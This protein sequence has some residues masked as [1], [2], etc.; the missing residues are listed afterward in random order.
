MEMAR[1]QRHPQLKTHQISDTILHSHSHD[2]GGQAL[3][4]ALLP[5]QNI[6]HSP[7]KKKRTPSDLRRLVHNVIILH[8]TM[9]H[10]N[11]RA[12]ATGVRD[13]TIRNTG[14][15]YTDIMHVAKH[16]QCVP[17]TLAKWTRSLTTSTEIRP[18]IPFDVVSVDGLGPYEPPTIKGCKRAI[19][20]IDC[21]TG[22]MMGKLVRHYNASTLQEFL[23]EIFQ[24]AKQHQFRVRL[25]RYDAGV[26]E[27]SHSV[28]TFLAG[29]GVMGRPATPE[30]QHQNPVERHIRTLKET[31]AANM[32]AQA[33]LEA[34]FWGHGMTM[35]IQQHNM[36]PNSLCETSPNVEIRDIDTDIRLQGTHYFGETVVVEKMGRKA[37][38]GEAR[39]ELARVVGISSL[40]NGGWI[41]VKMG[42]RR[43]MV[44]YNPQ[45]ISNFADD[46]IQQ[47]GGDKWLP[48][49]GL[50]GT[51]TFTSRHS[52]S[53]QQEEAGLNGGDNSTEKGDEAV[54]KQI[55]SSIPPPQEERQGDYNTEEIADET[56]ERTLQHDTTT[57][58]ITPWAYQDRDD[59]D[60]DTAQHH[61]GEVVLAGE[62][63]SENL[64]NPTQDQDSRQPISTR[65]S[66]RQRTQT[67]LYSPEDPHADER[68]N[69]FRAMSLRL[70]TILQS[71]Q[72]K[73]T[74]FTRKQ[75]ERM[76]DAEEWE[77][78]RT[79]EKNMLLSRQT[80]IAEEPAREDT[81]INTKWTHVRKRDGTYKARLCCRGDQDSYDGETFAPTANKSIVWL[82]IAIA[83]ILSLHIR[84][85]DISGA[86]IA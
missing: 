62:A 15:S 19:I 77:K 82:I 39:N 67:T 76:P 83:V 69:I 13:N 24:F 23:R 28:A 34:Y 21:C 2:D 31:L 25:L 70:P 58:I 43:P 36:V 52:T 79:K 14:L 47:L 54:L 44:R 81:I 51:I 29:E 68:V 63:E 84:I 26:I 22:F 48:Q 75:T 12:L 7:T 33:S 8:K 32:C 86:F 17:C 10:V 59:D 71:R 78:A 40:T 5:R 11:F 45:S 56:I 49:R 53:K 30:H 38:I 64:V 16:I 55:I 57:T 42:S 72:A 18:N 41:V 4:M 9:G 80:W 46:D 1:V 20:A 35:S 65:M 73:T 3:R 60:V 6:G 37:P 74:A 85:I 50:D 66:T 27:N 61:S